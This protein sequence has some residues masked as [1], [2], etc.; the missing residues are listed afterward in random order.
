[1]F[2]FNHYYKFALTGNWTVTHAQIAMSTRP[3]HKSEHSF[4]AA[5]PMPSAV[6]PKRLTRVVKFAFDFVIKG[7]TNA[8]QAIGTKPSFDRSPAAI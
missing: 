1:M 2:L 8:G 4:I 6:R 3:L 7:L 5:T